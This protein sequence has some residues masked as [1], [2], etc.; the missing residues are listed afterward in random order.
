MLDKFPP[1][2]RYHRTPTTM[3]TTPD[4]RTVV[5]LRRR[6]VP[7]PDQFSLLREYTV[8]DGDRLDRIAA[9]QLGDP[10][11]YWQICDANNAVVP[12]ELTATPGRVLRITLPEGIPGV[13]DAT[14]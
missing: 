8:S 4:G 6:F 11:M 10:E 12:D 13:D 14:G 7:P 1:N 9:E 2:S 3:R 5:Y